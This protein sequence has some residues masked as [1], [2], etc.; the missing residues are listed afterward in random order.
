MCGISTNKKNKQTKTCKEKHIAHALTHKQMMRRRRCQAATASGGGALSPIYV[1]VCTYN[2][3]PL[4]DV[5]IQKFGANA[6]D[7]EFKCLNFLN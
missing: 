1:Y 6:K 7:N 3:V 4:H 5:P 2:L